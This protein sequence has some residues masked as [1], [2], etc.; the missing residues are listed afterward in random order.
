APSP[1]PRITFASEE[2]AEHAGYR[3]AG[4]G[5]WGT[6]CGGEGHAVTVVTEK[7]EG[8]SQQE[9]QRRGSL[10]YTRIGRAKLRFGS[11]C[12][13]RRDQNLCTHKSYNV[14][15]TA[16][17]SRG[18][19]CAA[20]SV[21]EPRWRMWPSIRR[22]RARPKS[23]A[24]VAIGFGSPSPRRWPPAIAVRSVRGKGT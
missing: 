5:P 18:R 17:S 19:H 16:T 6:R 15:S 9:R 23:N 3:K 8:P 10:S 13:T 24:R 4:H 7:M 20:R 22:R 11:V 2:A 12:N 21:A 1:A 14:P